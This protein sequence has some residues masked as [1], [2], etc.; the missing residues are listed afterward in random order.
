M[1]PVLFWNFLRPLTTNPLEYLIFSTINFFKLILMRQ[2]GTKVRELAANHSKL[3]LY[4]S[5]V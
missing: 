4:A 5:S 2:I 1:E 3:Y